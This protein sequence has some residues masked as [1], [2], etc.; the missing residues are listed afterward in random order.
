MVRSYIKYL[1]LTLD[2]RWSFRAHF[3]G[4]TPRLITFYKC[5]WPA[6]PELAGARGE[7]PPSLSGGDTV[8]GPIWANA[9]IRANVAHLRRLHRA[10]AIRAIR[11]YCTIFGEAACLLARSPPWD[12]EAK[13][14]ASLYLWRAELRA[15]GEEPDSGALRARKLQER[16]NVHAEWETRLAALTAGHR[17]IERPVFSPL[18]LRLTQVLTGHS[19]FGKY[20]CN[21]Y[22]CEDC[23]VDK[24]QHT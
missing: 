15:R 17:T 21:C 8:Y 9:L 16:Q 7:L 18:T 24:A 12:L 20:L 5:S 14:G 10:I 13:A 2:G 1:G 11:G 23:D 3:R 19:C 22:E 4:L 6:T